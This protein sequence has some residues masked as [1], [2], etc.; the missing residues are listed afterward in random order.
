MLTKLLLVLC[1]TSIETCLFPSHLS[2]TSD[3]DGSFFSNYLL[4][5]YAR[6]EFE[7]PNFDWLHVDCLSV[8]F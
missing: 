4:E 2:E 6:E 1:Q 8:A 7:W 3:A 5:I